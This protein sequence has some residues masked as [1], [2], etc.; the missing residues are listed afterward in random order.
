MGVKNMKII[1]ACGSGVATSTLF[2]SKVEDILKRNNLRAQVIQCSL[3]EVDGY[4][5]GATLVV[6]SMARLKV[7][8]VPMVVALPYL[9]GVGA[10]AT[11]AEIERILLENKDN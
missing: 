10:E 9:T 5:K 1:I 7:E 3:N 4:L 11:D 8:G 6:T 2:A